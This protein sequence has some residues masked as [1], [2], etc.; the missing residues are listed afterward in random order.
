MNILVLLKMVPDIVEE[1]EVGP[2]KTSLDLEFL[3]LII[4]ESD[5]HALEQALILKDRHGGTV[6]A[7][8]LESP[9][10]DDVL[11]NA[12]AKGAD[13]AIRVTDLPA[14]LTNRM[15]AGVLA[16]VLPGL[17]PVDL[18]LTGCYAI[19]DLDGVIAPLVAEQLDLPYLG[20]V[21]QVEADPAAA[22]A[23]VV[24]EF[25]GGVRGAFT[26]PLPALL[27]VQAA[28]KPPRYVPVAKV[29]AAMK[30]QEIETMAAP[31]TIEPSPVHVRELAKPETAGQAEML[32]GSP[33]EMAQKLFELFSD[34]GLLV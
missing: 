26:S 16:R 33:E 28:E 25:P 27:G 6:T 23:R 34:R 14:G 3:R 20:I 13:R 1:L 19:D 32:E 29:R 17:L 10:I 31:E 11:Y 2:D 9:E 7:L 21:T 24:K 4:N 12:L 5:D 8:A 15:A 18:V 22:T 30:S